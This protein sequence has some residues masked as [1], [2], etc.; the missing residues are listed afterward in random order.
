MTVAIKVIAHSGVLR[1][2]KAILSFWAIFNSLNVIS[3]IGDYTLKE[4]IAASFLGDDG[5]EVGLYG[6]L[7]PYNTKPNYMI[8]KKCNVASRATVDNKL[9]VEIEVISE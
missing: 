5:T 4:E 7:Y 9:S 3:S 1:P 8:V 2:T 6:G